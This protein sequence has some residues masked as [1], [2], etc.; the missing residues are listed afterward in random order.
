MQ[1]YPIY[2]VSFS[3]DEEVKTILFPNE[4]FETCV[5]VKQKGVYGL[6]FRV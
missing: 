2:Y 3:L 5:T 1:A 6:G 4:N